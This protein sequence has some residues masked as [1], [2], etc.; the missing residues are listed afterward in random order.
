M[1]AILDFRVKE[2]P[3]KVGMGTVKKLTLEN[4]SITFGILSLGGTKPEYTP[5]G[6]IYPPP[7][8]TYVLKNTIA[9]LGLIGKWGFLI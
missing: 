9:T 6:V 4:M 8:A 5:G 2:S 3:V 1:G 7:V